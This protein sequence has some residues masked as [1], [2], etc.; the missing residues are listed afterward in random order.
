AAQYLVITAPVLL[1]TQV[2]V[3]YEASLRALG[4]TTLPLV[5]GVISAIANILLNYVLIYGHWG[6]PALGVAGAAWGTLIAR[7]LQLAVVLVWLYG[8]KH[9]FALDLAALRM[10]M[11][12]VQISRYLAF[13][14]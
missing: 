3:I 11:D 10:G 14:L 1:L 13:A 5:A 6:F 2:V 4:Q 9:G 8:R 12:K 7:A